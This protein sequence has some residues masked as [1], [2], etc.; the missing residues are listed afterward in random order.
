M[1]TPNDPYNPYGNSG[2]TGD[3]EQFP[4]YGSSEPAGEAGQTGQDGYAGYNHPEND[5][6]DPTYNSYSSYGSAYV[7]QGIGAEAGQPLVTNAGPLPVFESISYGFKRVFSP[8][9][10]VY[11]GLALIPMLLSVVGLVVVIAPMLA[12]MAADPE[13]YVPGAGVFAGFGVFMIVGMI[14]SLAFQIVLTKVALRDSAGETP[15]WQN[16]FKDVP[17]GQGFLVHILVGLAFGIGGALLLAI[18]VIVAVTLSPAVGV[19]LGILVVI[20]CV[21]LYPF[22]ALIPLYA[23]DGRTNAVGAFSAAFNDIKPHYW[24]VLGA[25]VVI[26]VISGLLVSF[27]SGVSSLIMA[28]VTALV[29]VFVY[30][31]I[32]DRHEQPVQQ[33]GY[34]S[35]Y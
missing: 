6:Y 29:S 19:V 11:M 13:N 3:N 14:V 25:M 10:H 15:S 22:I 35:M 9:W 28:P 21:F 8:Q 30:R 24:R 16:A 1:T 27:T 18:P 12:G 34:M 17:W 20:G 2:N 33:D 5:N 31:W 23:I 4:R 7:D 26:G 32:S